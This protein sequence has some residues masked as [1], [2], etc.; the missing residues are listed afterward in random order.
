MVHGTVHSRVVHSQKV[1]THLSF[2]T[3]DGRAIPL[4]VMR[5][6]LSGLGGAGT[7]TTGASTGGAGGGAATPA[8]AG[9][10]ALAPTLEQLL[11]Q[12]AQTHMENAARPPQD[13]TQAGPPAG[14]PGLG[15]EPQ[16]PPPTIGGHNLRPRQRPRA[17]SVPP[18][19]TNSTAPP[20]GPGPGANPPNADGQANGGGAGGGAPFMPP[21]WTMAGIPGLPPGI[22]GLGFQAVPPLP[23]MPPG[24]AGFGFPGMTFGPFMAGI[25]GMGMEMER[26]PDTRRAKELLRG[27][28]AVPRGLVKRMERVEKMLGNESAESG[29]LVCA[30]CYDPLLRDSDATAA[31]ADVVMDEADTEDADADADEDNTKS[32]SKSAKTK[33]PSLDPNAL[34]ALPCTHVFHAVDCLLPWFEQGKTTCPT[35]RFDVDP[36]SETLNLARWLG[37]R[38]TR[39]TAPAGTEAANNNT[40]APG[41][42]P[43][44]PAAAAATEDTRMEGDDEEDGGDFIEE[45]GESDVSAVFRDTIRRALI[46]ALGQALMPQAGDDQAPPN[47]NANAPTPG[48]A[49]NAPTGLPTG[50]QPDPWAPNALRDFMMLDV[51]GP[52]G[53]MPGS[54]PL[55]PTD[56]EL[57]GAN[58]D[59]DG[60][61]LRGDGES[62]VAATANS[63]PHTTN[64]EL[65]RASGSEPS[66]SY[67]NTRSRR[68]NAPSPSPE[69]QPQ[70]QQQQPANPPEASE[71]IGR[72]LFDW[73]R[74]TGFFHRGTP[75]TAAQEQ[76]VAG[77]SNSTLNQTASPSTSAASSR[78]ATPRHHPYANARPAPSSRST[79]N[80]NP[81]PAPGNAPEPSMMGFAPRMETAPNGPTTFSFGSEMNNGNGRMSITRH[82][83]TFNLAVPLASL[84][85]PGA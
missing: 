30:V 16:E 1:S 20:A 65:P 75:A 69:V 66:R 13:P 33:H 49:N 73:S 28:T 23:G 53:D 70:P 51:F 47:A 50:G 19:S 55:V 54:D 62:S 39:T 83:I 4:T 45:E 34:I 43:N 11:A 6:F 31:P 76:P 2:S 85:N 9:P 61:M 17:A 46:S 15:Q 22:Q 41:T 37:R 42:V 36:R 57:P 79:S 74:Y 59:Q 29:K 78:P 32:K 3:A 8:G 5:Q 72:S 24:L 56:I 44:P 60:R 26:P 67:P 7:P 71:R 40:A 82:S 77:P 63:T 27:L 80:L 12:H 68:E 84:I 81:N 48:T 35:C 14:G 38:R 58:R 21:G 64:T 25:P 52:G 18:L 10:P